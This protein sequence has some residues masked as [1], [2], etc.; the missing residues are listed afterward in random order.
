MKKIILIA[1]LLLAVSV[2]YAANL[3]IEADKQS[4]QDKNNKA[5]FEG[6]VKVIFDDIV[7]KSPTA[8]AVLDPKTKKINEANFTEKAYV[9]QIKNNKKNE[10]KADIIKISLLNKIVSAKGNTQTVVTENKQLQPTVV[11]TADSQEYNTNTKIMHAKGNVVVNYKDTV[12]YSQ[13]GLAKL[14]KNG[15][16]QELQLV[17][18]VR[19]QQNENRFSAQRYVYKTVS[20]DAIATGNVY[21]EMKNN[22]GST[23]V[24]QSEFQQYNKRAN[25]LTASKNVRIKYKDYYAQGPKASVFPDD[26]TKKLNKVVLAGRSKI[27]ESGRTIEA[28]KIYMT[29]TPKNFNAEGH[30]KTFIPNVSS[31]SE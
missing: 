24:V 5:L 7:V 11:I 28:D 20:E 12:S 18:N 30:V 8:N 10:V 17:G 15:D 23:I 22:D 25:T 19:I 27:T 9:Y 13:E 6:N 26:A 21:S 14:D 1:V 4:F 3:S 29:L 2:G 16:V 31:M